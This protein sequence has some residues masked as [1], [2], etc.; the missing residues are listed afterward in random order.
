MLALSA[1]FVGA[2]N[3]RSRI[4]ISGLKWFWWCALH[5]LWSGSE[6]TELWA[7]RFSFSIGIRRQRPRADPVAIALPFE[8]FHPGT[9]D[10]CTIWCVWVASVLGRVS[11]ERETH[12][13]VPVCVRACARAHPHTRA[14]TR[15]RT[16]AKRLCWQN[17]NFAIN[18]KVKRR[19]TVLFTRT[20]KCARKTWNSPNSEWSKLE[21]I[22]KQ[23]CAFVMDQ[24]LTTHRWSSC[25]MRTST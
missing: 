10:R 14:R 5:W 24:S 11:G 6:K 22:T 4:W 17:H 9:T 19:R 25:L 12:A 15:T 2:N 23:V 8:D 16:T 20:P 7:L 18:C 3:L 21:S 13:R 1:L